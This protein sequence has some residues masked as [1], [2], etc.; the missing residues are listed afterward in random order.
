MNDFYKFTASKRERT[1]DH[2]PLKSNHGTGINLTTYRFRLEN[3]KKFLHIRAITFWNNLELE[4][5]REEKKTIFYQ[6][7]DCFM[8]GMTGCGCLQYHQ[9]GLSDPRGPFKSLFPINF[10]KNNNFVSK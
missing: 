9:T 10:I 1:G 7:F 6:E 2:N 5:K 8:K 4:L 3:R